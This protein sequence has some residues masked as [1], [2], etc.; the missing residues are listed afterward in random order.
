MRT[1][2]TIR[3]ILIIV[4]E[5]QILK[6]FQIFSTHYYKFVFFFALVI[7]STLCTYYIL[8]SL[9][10]LKVHSLVKL[11]LYSITDEKVSFIVLLY[12]RHFQESNPFDLVW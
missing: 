11:L 4:F 3:I 7:V 1:I 6:Q 12:P 8:C 9:N 5:Y 2:G 10:R